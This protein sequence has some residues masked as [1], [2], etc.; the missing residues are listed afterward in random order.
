MNTI[1]ELLLARAEQLPAT[2]TVADI[3]HL[4]AELSAHRDL[5]LAETSDGAR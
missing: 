2:A 3:D 5:M 4:I 1:T